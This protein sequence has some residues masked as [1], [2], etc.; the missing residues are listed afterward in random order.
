V[1]AIAGCSASPSSDV[2]GPFTG[3]LQRFVI[4]TITVPRDSAQSDAFAADLDGDGRSENQLGLVTAVL[5]S[6]NDLSLHAP[7]MIASGA[8]VS[9]IEIQADD[10]V[11]DDTVGVRYLGADG[12]LATVAGGRFVAGSFRSNRTFETRVPGRALVRLPVYANADP[13]VLAL[14][15]LELDLEPD[16]RGGF[17]AIVRGGVREETAREAAYTGLVQMFETEPER[18]LVFA[19]QIDTD[20]DGTLSRQEMD[21]SVIALLV[22]ADVHMFDGERYAPRRG[23]AAD[24]LSFGFAVHLAPC[25]S[26]SCTASGPTDPCRDRVRD[27]DET[28]VDCGGSCQACAAALACTV[29]NDCQTRACD[30]GR[31]RVATCGDGVRDGYE[32]DVDC[33][34]ICGACQVGQRCAA[35]SDCT[36]AT[37]DN[38][39]GSTGICIAPG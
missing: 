35:D 23:A 16:G 2:I 1:V 9:S 24:V 18:H 36:G 4:D 21:D 25:A 27:G 14:D 11:D 6:T 30:V 19:R 22:A 5:A 32:S 20:G 13:L 10:L 38:G 29:P 26:G 15:G 3:E 8:L 37:C 28:D 17:D 7:D 39:I 31:C 34:G 33:G 12:E